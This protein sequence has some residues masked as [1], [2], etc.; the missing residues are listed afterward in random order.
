MPV[1]L[2]ELVRQAPYIF[3]GQL[4][5]LFTGLKKGLDPDNPRNLSRVVVL[6]EEAL[7]E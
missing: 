4:T 6:A 7:A 1:C 2:P 5:G 3:C